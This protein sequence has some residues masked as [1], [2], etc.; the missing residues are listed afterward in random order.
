MASGKRRIVVRQRSRGPG[1]LR[2]LFLKRSSLSAA[3][4]ST[5]SDT[6]SRVDFRLQHRTAIRVVRQFTEQIETYQLHSR[7]CV[8]VVSR[9]LVPSDRGLQETAPEWIAE[10]IRFGIVRGGGEFDYI[11]VERVDIAWD[12]EGTE[13]FLHLSEKVEPG[14]RAFVAAYLGAGELRAVPEVPG[15]L[16]G[17]S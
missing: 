15:L 2:R 11:P 8:H 10:R 3:P 16:I 12:D 9:F 7:R 17:E 1:L 4:P 5:A 6:D 13:L 14:T